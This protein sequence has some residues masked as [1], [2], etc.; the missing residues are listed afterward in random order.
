MLVMYVSL[1]GVWF[2]PYLTQA[3]DLMLP[4][5]QLYF[6]EGVQEVVCRLVGYPPK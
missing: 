6:H 1:L 4:T 5:F 3:L 2:M